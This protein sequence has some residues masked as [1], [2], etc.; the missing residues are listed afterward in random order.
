MLIRHNASVGI[1]VVVDGAQKNTHEKKQS[2]CSRSGDKSTKK[3]L[4]KWSNEPMSGELLTHPVVC[5]EER[6]RDYE[7]VST[8][9]KTRITVICA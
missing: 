6:H 5:E 7:R 2:K 1:S 8:C 3:K 4:K 9:T